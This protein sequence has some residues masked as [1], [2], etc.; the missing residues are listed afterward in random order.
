MERRKEIIKL[1]DKSHWFYQQHILWLEG[2]ATGEPFLSGRLQLSEEIIAKYTVNPTNQP[3][4][5]VFRPN[6]SQLP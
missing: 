4:P 5:V 2:Q 3:I 6:P 1:L